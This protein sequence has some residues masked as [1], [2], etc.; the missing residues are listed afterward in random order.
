MRTRFLGY[1]ADHDPLRT[2]TS[3]WP[4]PGAAVLWRLVNGGKITPC[5]ARRR[6]AGGR[7][8][9]AAGYREL[10]LVAAHAKVMPG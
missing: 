5:F 1:H 10:S 4:R 3:A 6:V 7:I 8:R 9:V 2:S